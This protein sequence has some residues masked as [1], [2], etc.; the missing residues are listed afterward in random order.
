MASV[1]YPQI[2]PVIDTHR[3]FPE[4]GCMNNTLVPEFMP[5][6]SCRISIPRQ[7]RQDGFDNF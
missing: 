7:R 3:S 4:Y 2:S 6:S 5:L 1:R